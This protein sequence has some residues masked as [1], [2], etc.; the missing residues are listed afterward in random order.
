MQERLITFLYLLQDLREVQSKSFYNANAVSLAL[1]IVR[2]TYIHEVSFQFGVLFY[3][4]GSVCSNIGLLHQ[5]VVNINKVVLKVIV[6]VR[7][8]DLQAVVEG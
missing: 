6:R 4:S 2:G 7:F 3:P 8:Y 5:Q 1:S